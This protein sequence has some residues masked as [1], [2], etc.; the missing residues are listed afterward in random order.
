M[1]QFL[2]KIFGD[3]SSRYIKSLAPIVTIVNNLE[4]EIVLLSDTDFPKETQKLRDR[5]T[6]GET[7]EQLL[8]RAF[9]LARE[10]GKRT[11]NERH[12]DVQIIG[13][14]TL[15]HGKIAEMRTGEGKTLVA[16]L[17]AYLNA[18][19]GNSVH[20]VTV[21]DYLARR[22]GELMGQVYRFLGLSV[23]IINDGKSFIYNPD[24]EIPADIDEMEAFKVFPEFL[25]TV[26]K[27][28]AYA[29]DVVYGTN[30]QFGFDYLR[31]NMQNS[32]DGMVQGGHFFAI[33]DEVDSVLIDEARVPL[34]MSTPGNTA[35]DLYKTFAD[36]ARTM[37]RDTDYTVDEKQKAISLTEAGITRAEQL[38]NVDNLY[39]SENIKL[40]H[41]LETALRAEALFTINNEYLVRGGEVLIVD[42]FTG[43]VLD[44][45]RYQDGLHQAL[46]AK[47]GVTI[48]Q[49]SRTAASVTYQNYFKLYKKLAGMTGTGKTSAEEFFKVYNL[50]VVEIPTYRPVARMDHND[51]IYQTRDGKYRALAKHVRKLYDKGQPVLVGTVSIENNEVI[52]SYLKNEGIPHE[53]LNAKNHDREAEIIAQAG[54]AKSVVVATN[55]AG[56]GVDIKLGGI[57]FDKDAYEDIKSRGGLFVIGT[58]RHEARR[59]DNQ[60]RGRSGRQ[61]DPGETQFYVSLEDDLVRVFG[62][63]KVKGM[64][65]K[66]GIPADE[67]I[68]HG[69]ISKQLEGAQMKIEGF[70]FDSRKDTLAYD[71]VL[72]TQRNSIYERR[73]KILSEDPEYVTNTKTTII[74]SLSPEQLAKFETIQTEL[75]EKFTHVFCQVLLSVIDQL[76]MD[77]LEM[78][79][80]A[81]SSVNLRSY[82]Q[83]EPLVE[84]KREGLHMFRELESN[85]LRQT[86]NIIMSLN[87]AQMNENAPISE[88]KPVTVSIPTTN[89]QGTKY[90]QN[91]RII[92]TKNGEIQEV[93]YKKL[94]QY[95]I[96][97]WTIK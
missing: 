81:R 80:H 66:L 58:E 27:K 9:A 24:R 42:Q 17:P 56:R 36:I 64:I 50:E 71:D 88:L 84:Y 47:E 67:A 90:G 13:G 7:L 59:I 34:I 75:G 29:C 16:T 35:E 61:G 49:E 8:P 94:D 12:Y 68:Q 54:R 77:H 51:L 57:P 74:E 39:T 33:V 72:A 41:H 89:T 25:E 46:E 73:Y 11:L 15:H 32:L 53:V 31:D 65:G 52:S 93:K 85:L 60:L 96:D 4:P 21:N 3:E 40:I 76:W 86:A 97:G 62:G 28:T 10:A 6:A 48:K 26:D 30:T 69:F 92:I 63:D 22:D 95:L 45:R 5:Y 91:D 44:G 23:G 87:T 19:T 70:H 20:I 1:K 14:I 82:G 37:H 18:I 43:R 55:M 2:T 38:L 78:M 83:R 79:E